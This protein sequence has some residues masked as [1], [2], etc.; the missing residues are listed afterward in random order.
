M[1]VVKDFWK[2]KEGRFRLIQ[3]EPNT[4][5]DAME[6]EYGTTDSVEEANEFLDEFEGRVD[7]NGDTVGYNWGEIVHIKLKRN[8][9][10]E[11]A[12]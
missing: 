6:E 9:E 12:D 7:Y 3:M 4:K 5:G 8:G 1:A 10:P 11:I 2:V